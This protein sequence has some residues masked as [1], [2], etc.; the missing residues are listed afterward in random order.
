MGVIS[1]GIKNAFRNTVRSLSITFILA[2]AIAMSLVMLLALK[3][4]QSKIDGVKGSI[5]NVIT[6][7]PAGV[8]GF[9][10][11]GTLLATADGN[12]I[13]A[14]PNV[15]KTTKTISERMRKDTDTNLQSA[16]DPGSFGQR[17]QQRNSTGNNDT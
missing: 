5:G 16:I 14:L 12:T 9:E 1:R 3:T 11:G 13:S 10:G 15:A 17:Q 8:R 7:S 6:V 2:L 4:V